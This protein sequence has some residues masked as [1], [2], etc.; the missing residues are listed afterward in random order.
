MEKSEIGCFTSCRIFLENFEKI[1]II[2]E[3]KKNNGLETRIL[4]FIMKFRIDLSIKPI[5]GL[6][7]NNLKSGATVRRPKYIYSMNY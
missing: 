7:P 1:T 3:S 5:L 4:F 6:A 2:L